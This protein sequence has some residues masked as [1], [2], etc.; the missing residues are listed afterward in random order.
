MYF[1]NP[2]LLM[3][4]MDKKLDVKVVLIV[5]FNHRFD[6]NLPR[7]R[8][9]YKDRF[10]NIFFLVPFYSGTD[11]DVIAVYESSDCYQ[12]YFAQAYHHLKKIDYDYWFIIADDMIINPA[13]NEFNFADNFGISID[14]SFINAIRK[15]NPATQW[16]HSDRA[17]RFTFNNKF[18]Q[19]R[20]ELPDIVLAK[21]YLDKYGISPSGLKFESVY[22]EASGKP[23][24]Y[25]KYG[26]RL[27]ADIAKKND[28]LFPEYPFAYG[29]SDI[30]CIGKN[31]IERFCH[32]CGCFAA[33][34]LFVEIAVPTALIFSTRGTLY[35]QKDI[36]YQ[37]SALWSEDEI[38]DEL[39]K[40]DLDLAKLI[41]SFPPEKLFLHPVKL[42]MWK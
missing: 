10:S 9:I 36:H 17:L 34:R 6:K 23:G 39:G 30:L 2:I 1:D 21:S 41:R 11:E 18:L 8:E 35:T 27:S 22:P 7:L 28:L 29:Y 5:V 32:Y 20:N 24:D 14:D 25:A 42:S 37:G 16:A 13:I 15:F 33:A 31:N 40:F 3:T 12:G 38:R 4:Q 26:A 19:I